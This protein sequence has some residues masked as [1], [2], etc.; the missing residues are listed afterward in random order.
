[1]KYNVENYIIYIN[2]ILPQNFINIIIIITI[3]LK[4]EFAIFKS[5]RPIRV[6]FIAVKRANNELSRYFYLVLW[7]QI[8]ALSITNIFYPDESKAL[9][10][11]DPAKFSPHRNLPILCGSLN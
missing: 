6:L 4:F 1:M 11:H 2:I 9:P 5:C 8:P 3:K 7:L 10:R